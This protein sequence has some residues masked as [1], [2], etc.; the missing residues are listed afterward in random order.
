MLRKAITWVPRPLLPFWQRIEGSPLAYRM[1]RG[2]V[3]SA[4]GALSSRV[5]TLIS[6]VTVA[7]L[8][9]REAFGKVG[10]IN[11]TV[12]MFALFSEFGMG[13]TASKFVA[14]FRTS[15]PQR[16]GRVIAL[17]SSTGWLTGG[18]MTIALIFAAPWLAAHTLAAPSLALP[19]R[20]SSPLLL[21]GSLMGA[22]WGVLNGFEA[23]KDVARIN[24]LS[25]AVA[26][27][28][29]IAGAWLAGVN[30]VLLG[31]VATQLFTVVI[32]SIVVRSKIRSIGVK[33]A[34]R[35][36]FHELEIL[37]KFS[38][39]AVI[40][41][42]M[43]TPTVW[44]CSAFIV[45]TRG[46]Y[47]EMGLYNAANQWRTAIVMFP[48]L[49]ANVAL[50]MLS[51][52]RGEANVKAYRRLLWTNLK[53]SAGSAALMGLA[54]A[55]L[56]PLLMRSYGASFASGY[57]VLIILCAVSVIY[58]TV[59]IVGQA[60][61]SE[62]RMWVGFMLNAVWA[63]AVLSSTWLLRG[64]GAQGLAL[65]YLIAYGLL[66]LTSSWY[67]WLRFSRDR[68]LVVEPEAIPSLS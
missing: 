6:A 1:V 7:H 46:G 32:T 43:V 39:P 50:P 41:A 63:V 16:A 3:W 53:I 66:T 28:L 2:T 17:S 14:E 45:N 49:L 56:S 59:D 26:F 11:G 68:K 22:R 15:D 12:G 35:H 29:A 57:P 65:A 27:P 60:I 61:A 52:L 9:G 34:F 4:V 8:L 37:W 30:G 23:F 64:R 38:I 19:L 67:V 62:G 44:A 5:L 51:N 42:A 13:L 25:G 20:L 24:F 36:A 33:V 55:C 40:S 58:A 21:L 54:I 10:V 18:V 31:V 47:S 48:M